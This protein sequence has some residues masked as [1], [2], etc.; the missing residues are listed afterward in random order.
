[1]QRHPEGKNPKDLSTNTKLKPS[2]EFVS[3][4]QLTNKFYPLT[5]R[6]GSKNGNRLINL[7][8]YKTHGLQKR[9]ELIP[10]FPSPLTT[11]AC[12]YS[13]TWTRKL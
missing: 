5:K 6:E 9:N 2:P 7:S 13:I 4:P 3:S 8:T 12:F 10:L 1:M 11:L